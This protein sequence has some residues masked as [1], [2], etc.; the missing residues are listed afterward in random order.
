MTTSQL[1]QKP[2]F[3]MTTDV[4]TECTEKTKRGILS[5][6]DSE[7]SWRVITAKALL[8][9]PFFSPPKVRNTKSW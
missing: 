3:A 7:A 6:H 2:V 8:S 4:S 9:F 5:G 1:Q